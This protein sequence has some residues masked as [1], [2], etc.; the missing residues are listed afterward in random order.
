MF[1]PVLAT[2]LAAATSS[3]DCAELGSLRS[4]RGGAARGLV[5]WNAT[6]E[7][8]TVAWIN[9][10]GHLAQPT[11][12]LPG[13]RD[14]TG[15]YQGHLFAFFDGDRCL[16]IIA[17]EPGE[18]VVVAGPA[19][20]LPRKEA[21]DRAAVLSAALDARY[22][23]RALAGFPASIGREVLAQPEGEEAL[24]LI[25]AKLA[26][27]RV[28]LK[29]QVGSLAPVSIR[30]E[31]DR[32]DGNLRYRP[33][34]RVLEISSA[35]SLLHSKS[36]WEPMVVLHELSHAVVDLWL[37]RSDPGLLAAYRGA[38]A[39]DAY[40][41]VDQNGGPPRA[42]YALTKEDE[43]FAELS[44]AYFGYND[45]FPHTR[46]QLERVDAAGYALMQRAW[47]PPPPRLE[48]PQLAC[49]AASK[50]ARDTPR[51]LVRFHN[52]T[53]HPLAVVWLDFDG[54]PSPRGTLAPG[55]TREQLTFEGHAFIFKSGAACLAAF[56][57]GREPAVAEISA[58]SSP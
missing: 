55:A 20:L 35:K 40:A 36:K 2:L 48:L 33:A 13:E 56:V 45:W 12:V 1:L 22:V 4:P 27:S 6:P 28:L 41:A 9:R 47:G 11:T 51:T 46:E 14:S 30:I 49:G 18:D 7:P 25:E 58:K 42:A 15:T 29:E 16:G 57:A 19:G 52:A 5:Y 24:R 38:V 54:R 21:A 32:G 37:K 26:E 39:S 31:W 34:E 53:D 43:Y 50:S 44:E 10:E 8:L 3:P 17:P 23:R